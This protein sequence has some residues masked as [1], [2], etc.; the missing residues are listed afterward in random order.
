M[1][2]MYKQWILYR[3]QVSACDED[4]IQVDLSI[5][6]DRGNHLQEN[7]FSIVS[8]TGTTVFDSEI[9]HVDLFVLFEQEGLNVAI[10]IPNEDYTFRYT[11]SAGNGLAAG[12]IKVL[13]NQNDLCTIEQRFGSEAI[14]QFNPDGVFQ[15]EPGN[16]ENVGI[17]ASPP[18]A[19]PMT[20]P[21]PAAAPVAPVI[22]P[23]QGTPMAPQVPPPNSPVFQQTSSAYIW[24]CVRLLVVSILL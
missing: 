15:C 8:S 11:D 22:P 21:A 16:V 19:D 2:R 7:E 5:V 9:D 13:I 24:G 4:Q 6:F 20:P 3:E 23:I 1:E 10:C 18:V 14:V 17:P 12:S